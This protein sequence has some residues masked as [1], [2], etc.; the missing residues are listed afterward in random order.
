[1]MGGEIS[2]QSEYGVG[3]VFTARIR[4]KSVNGKVI[5]PEVAENLKA[6]RY[7]LQKR[8]ESARLQRIRLPYAR[9][10]VVDDNA[11]NLDVA[12]GLMR[13][14]GMKVDCVLS[15]RQAIDAIREE[16]VKYDAVFMDHMMP[17]MDGI[18][19]AGLIR[20][21]GTRYARSVP[22]IALTANAIIGNKDMFLQNGFQDF[23]SKPVELAH[24]DAIIRK[25]VKS[26]EREQAHEDRPMQAD[27]DDDAP[28]SGLR[29]ALDRLSG[30]GRRES[31]M[32][33]ISGLDMARL[34]ARL[35]GNMQMCRHVLQSFVKHNRPL[36][37]EIDGV[38]QARLPGHA[39][40]VH[41]IKGAL[42]SIGGDTLGEKAEALEKASKA[43]DFDFVR[44]H[45]AAF[46]Q[47][48][49]QLM[50]RIDAFLCEGAPRES[51]PRKGAPDA[52]ALLRVHAAC[53]KYDI[54]E[55]DAAMAELEAF[56]YESGG[57]LVLWLR[58]NVDQMN[59]DEIVERLS[60][61]SQP[62]V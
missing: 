13:P 3:S 1:M 57:E 21:I 29:G 32:E 61:A 28:G 20:A 16:S 9:V 43:G 17:G 33:N 26:K 42:R 41:G 53:E 36:L 44:A 45:N 15:G 7:E 39:I 60:P 47:S 52:A 55:I 31:G 25:W 38:T 24:L 51:R 56:A 14:Y 30:N 40:A 12:K 46:V 5:G 58:E 48:A 49:R 10:L 4:Q 8:N 59:Y 18:E 11:T 27:G 37:D 54:D 34:T 6:F 22:I 19:A 23:I 50:D 2:V 35:G 62:E